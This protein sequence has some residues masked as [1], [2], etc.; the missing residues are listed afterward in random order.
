[1]HAPNKLRDQYSYHSAAE[2]TRDRRDAPNTDVA[3]DDAF[4]IGRRD[5]HQ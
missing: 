3:S 4:A 5:G 1:L 2:K